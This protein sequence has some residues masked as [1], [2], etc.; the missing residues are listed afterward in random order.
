MGFQRG[1]FDPNSQRRPTR[2]R[3][4]LVTHHPDG[5]PKEVVSE[6]IAKLIL[7]TYLFQGLE[8]GETLFIRAVRRHGVEG[9][10]DGRDLGRVRQLVAP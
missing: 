9:V 3:R 7:L 4:V 1:V 6:M 2:Y 8:A 10:R 5:R